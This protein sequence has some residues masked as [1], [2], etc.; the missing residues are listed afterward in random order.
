M[1]VFCV[2]MGKRGEQCTSTALF[3]SRENRPLGASPPRS[4][5]HRS[6][7][8]LAPRPYADGPYF[9]FLSIL[10]M[11]SST[12]CGSTSLVIMFCKSVIFAGSDIFVS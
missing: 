10:S 7:Q 3:D 5:E 1:V 8:H 6:H 2:C 9:R 12:W 4:D 11:A